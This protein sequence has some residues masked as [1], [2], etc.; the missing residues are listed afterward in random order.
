MLLDLVQMH[1]QKSYKWATEMAWGV[2]ARAN[3]GLSSVRGR[4]G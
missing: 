4:L 2:E 3:D 1:D